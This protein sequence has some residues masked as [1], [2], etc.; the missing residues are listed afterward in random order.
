[1]TSYLTHCALNIVRQAVKSLQFE[2]CAA[3]N[4]AKLLKINYR[5]VSD[6]HMAYSV[7]LSSTINSGSFAHLRLKPFPVISHN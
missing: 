1:M 3:I 6:N 7:L 2:E 5:K 4:P